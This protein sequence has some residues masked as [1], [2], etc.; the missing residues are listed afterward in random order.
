MVEGVP[1]DAGG[2]QCVPGQQQVAVHR[3]QFVGDIGQQLECQFCIQ[4]GIVY[5]HSRQ[6]G[7][8]ILLDEMMVGIL[9]VGQRAQVERV[10]G[11]Q[12]E[13]L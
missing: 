13:Q 9:G 6:R 2:E 4:K 1:R 12:V 8:L 5:L 11:G 7:F 3:F 10:D